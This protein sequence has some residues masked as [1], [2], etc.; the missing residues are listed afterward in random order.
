M[1]SNPEYSFNKKMSFNVKKKKNTHT[2]KNQL[3]NLI[4]STLTESF[5]EY[6]IKIIILI[7]KIKKTLNKEISC[8][9]CETL[10][11]SFNSN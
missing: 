6:Q 11:I 7:K 9:D 8:Q 5:L 3:I 4:K 1:F 10:K 2:Q